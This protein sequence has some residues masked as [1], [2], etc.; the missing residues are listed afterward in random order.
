MKSELVSI[1]M[2]AFNAEA[3]IHAS[4]QSVICQTYSNWELIV[5]DDGSSDSTMKIVQELIQEDSRIKLGVNKLTKGAAGARQSAINIS[6]GTY[7]AFLDSDDLWDKYKLDKS[8]SYMHE[9]GLLFTY[10]EYYIFNNVVNND[11]LYSVP[12]SLD[13]KTLLKYCPIGCLTVVIKKEVIKDVKFNNVPKEDYHF[14]L[15]IL[16]KNIIAYRVPKCYA[17]YRLGNKTLSSNKFKELYRQFYILYKTQNLSF[18]K[19][20]YCISIYAYNG[21]RKKNLINSAINV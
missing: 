13:Y 3:T 14:W 15:S 19:A 16:K 12:E 20:I 7:I 9:Y 1:I 21:L 5:I 8:I 18:F 6:K 2:P 4:I 11:C 17:Y 10:T